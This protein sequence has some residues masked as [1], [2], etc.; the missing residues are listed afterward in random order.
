MILIL[1]NR[2]YTLDE[3]LLILAMLLNELEDCK[4]NHKLNDIPH[5]LGQYLKD[6]DIQVIL[7][8]ILYSVYDTT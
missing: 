7:Q 5:I 6:I 4:N 8:S 1:Q 2:N 3:R